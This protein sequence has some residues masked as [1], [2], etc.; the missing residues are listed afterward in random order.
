MAEI[1]SEIFVGGTLDSDDEAR[2]VPNGRPRRADF[3]RMGTI[4]TGTQ[5]VRTTYD[6]N[7]LIPDL[8]FLPAGVNTVNGMCKWVEKRA[9]LIYYHNSNGDHSIVCYFADT[10]TFQLVEIFPDLLLDLN[11]PIID[12]CMSGDL[13]SFTDGKFDSNYFDPTSTDPLNQGRLFNPV[14]CINAQR[15][16][17]GGYVEKDLRSIEA[18]IWPPWNGPLVAYG[19]EAEKPNFLRSLVFEFSY[20]YI[21]ID[22]QVSTF[23][24]LSD[25][26]LP[27]VQEW[28]QGPDYAQPHADNVIYVTLNSGN[29]RVKKIRIA[30][31]VNNGFFMI[32]EEID[33]DAEG[34]ADD[35]TFTYSFYNNNTLYALTTEVG[36]YP[37][38]NS[39]M[40]QVAGKLEYLTYSNVLALGDIYENYNNQT[41]DYQVTHRAIEIPDFKP[42]Y[43]NIYMSSIGTT[44]VINFDSTASFDVSDGDTYTISV[45]INTPDLGDV[46]LT[47][48]ITQDDIEAAIVAFPGDPVQQMEF[49][50]DVIRQAFADIINN[51]FGTPFVEVVG[52]HIQ[53]IDSGVQPF[54]VQPFTRT[55][56]NP[57]KPTRRTGLRRTLKKGWRYYVAIQWYDRILRDG[58]VQKTLTEQI[59]DVPFPAFEEARA[60]FSDPNSPYYVQMTVSMNI[61]PPIWADCWKILIRKVK[62]GFA[63]F[64]MHRIDADPS[65]VGTYRM[66]LDVYYTNS[67]GA[68]VDYTPNVGDIVRVVTQ[69]LP[70]DIASLAPYTSQ[71]IELQVV[72]FDPSGGVGGRPAIWVSKFDLNILGEVVY[73]DAGYCSNLIEVFQAPKQEENSLWFEI[74][75]G[76]IGDAHTDTRYHKGTFGLIGDVSENGYIGESAVK[77]TTDVGEHDPDGR[78]VVF[79]NNDGNTETF[80]VLTTLETEPGVWKITIDGL[81]S[82]DFSSANGGVFAFQQ[83]QVVVGG[84]S[85]TPAIVDLDWGDVY[86]RQRVSDTGFLGTSNQKAYSYY[87]DPAVSDYYP[88]NCYHY[89][90]IGIENTENKATRYKADTMHSQVYLDQTSVNGLSDFT[91]LQNRFKLNESNGAI[92]R[93]KAVE[94]TLHVIQESCTT[95]I[96]NGTYSVGGDGEVSQPAFKNEIFGDKGREVPFGTI[97]PRSVQLIGNVVYLYDFNRATWAKLTDGGHGSINHGDF[98]YSTFAYN[99]TQLIQNNVVGNEKLFSFVDEL[100][101]E[102]TTILQIGED[103][104]G[105][106]FRYDVQGWSHHVDGLPMIWAENMYK[107]LIS[108]PETEIW[109]HNSGGDKNTF[110]DQYYPPSITFEM[111]DHPGLIKK[112]CGIGLK[113]D[114]TW[115]V[116]SVNV[117]PSVNYPS[118][119]QSQIPDSIFSPIDEYLWSSYL[120]DETNI[121]PENPELD[122]A[123]KA[124]VNGRDL[125][126]SSA[127]HKMT[128]TQT[129]AIRLFSIKIR[130][131]L[132]PKP[133]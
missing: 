27:T 125:I 28:V 21:A 124:L 46:L 117:S 81:F 7:L 34:I 109:L 54:F 43:A 79:T 47:Y 53:A 69:N 100:N 2:N 24:P 52:D 132:S 56:L 83:N 99:F 37:S 30:V 10:N 129:G 8:D 123:D 92:Q 31:R 82:F 50:E 73:T 65:L 11:Y 97:H 107:S 93:M 120:Q 75:D 78:V 39:K 44:I 80:T 51:D 49:I 64:M 33:K 115:R 14:F 19:S 3:F 45:K 70:I 91:G 108:T 105:V 127:I 116:D 131:D 110:F 63:Q 67:F 38:N 55:F 102:Y 32:C 126:G 59:L 20:Q 111:N 60:S 1:D 103:F 68:K 23:S 122:D 119:M 35:T 74:Y 9:I 40:P 18:A 5:G 133:R 114:G 72:K 130:S 113:T 106:V 48:A 13:N 88:S 62:T 57:V 96:Y 101:S 71:Y 94:K 77:T 26:A 112:F 36:A 104:Y 90:R 86:I 61:V 25:M 118:G 87:E 12:A 66:S 85:V 89:G 41:P 15:A 42:D 4:E 58:T 16:L 6:G 22:N 95:P 128:A 98:K 17:D 76:D 29:W 84:V 121:V